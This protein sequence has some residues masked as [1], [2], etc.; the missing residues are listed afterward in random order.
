M[1]LLKNNCR[2]QKTIRLLQKKKNSL[3][4]FIIKIYLFRSIS[5]INHF[6]NPNLFNRVS[7][8]IDILSFN[9][10]IRLNFASIIFLILL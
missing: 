4:T 5:N 10:H 6:S 3:V 7:S 9:T 8:I 1:L 2:L